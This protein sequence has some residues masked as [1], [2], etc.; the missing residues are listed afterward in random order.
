M[1]NNKFTLVSLLLVGTLQVRVIAQTPP[2]LQEVIDSALVQDYAFENKQLELRRIEL[3][4]ERIKDTYMPRIELNAKESYAYA[5]S[6]LTTPAFAIPQL[7]MA[8]PE[9]ENRYKLDNFITQADLKASFLLFSGGKV[10]NLKKANEARL[11]AETALLETDRNAIIQNVTAL[12]DQLAML[13]SVKAT[14][15]QSSKRLDEN[16]KVAEKA[17]SLGLITQYE[18]NKVTLAVSQL[19]AKYKEYEG[20]RRLVV[21]SLHTITKIEYDRLEKIEE[22]L[23]IMPVSYVDEPVNRPEITALNA[24]V[25]A[26]EYKVKAAKK[27]WV[28]KIGASASVGYFGLHN[29]RLRTTDPSLTT[30]QPLNH[31]FSSISATPVFIAGVGLKWD[32]F[33]GKEGIN[34]TKRAQIDLQIAQNK[35]DDVSEKITLQL[36]KQKVELE[37]AGDRLEVKKT[38]LQIAENSME[39]AM[40]E[41]KVG[42]IKSLQL[43]EAENDLQ[44]AQQEYAQ[45]I[46]Q[47]RRAAVQYLEAAGVLDVT[48]LK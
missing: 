39:Q 44:L 4:Q 5:A 45:A 46:F 11:E 6:N 38:A 28:P 22:D 43:L 34:E 20:K 29:G 42:L 23:I 27:W 36:E 8:F 31:T 12:Y 2:T 30:Q 48:T 41:F 1:K 40:K 16:L 32:L 25:L 33:D 15:D 35:R 3:D 26:N 10:S 19:A 37:I 24:A 14:L 21:L 13:K 7:Q 9:H 47:Q 18:Y 17:L